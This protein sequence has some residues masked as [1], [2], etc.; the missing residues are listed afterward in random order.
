MTKDEK[1]KI[2]NYKP[3][4]FVEIS[5]VSF[6]NINNILIVDTKNRRKINKKTI[7]WYFPIYQ[8]EQKYKNGYS[9]L[10]RLI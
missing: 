8:I 2:I 4:N 5:V 9:K 3:E 1:F 6:I 10:N 7:R